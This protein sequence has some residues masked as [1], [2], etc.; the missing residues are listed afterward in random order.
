VQGV[1]GG[2]DYALQFTGDGQPGRQLSDPGIGVVQLQQ[3][4]SA[5]LG[6]TG[7]LVFRINTTQ[8]GGTT[9]R[10]SPA[11]TGVDTGGSP[12]DIAW[13]WLDAQGHIG[14]SSGDAPQDTAMST[15]PVN[16]GRW[17]LVALTR[18][19]ATGKEQ[20]FIDGLLDSQTT[21]NTATKQ[22]PFKALG[23]QTEVG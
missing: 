6:G 4:L 1:T 3:D 8:K 13:G 22:V 18:D 16:D 7:S 9:A 11:I 14:I 12:D 19:A 10:L 15:T 21:G 2:S 5:I 23:A 20:V 17:H